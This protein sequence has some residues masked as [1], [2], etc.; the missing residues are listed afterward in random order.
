MSPEIRAAA[1]A[2]LDLALDAIEREEA[3]RQAPKVKRTRTVQAP[4]AP[5][6]SEVDP[7]MLE[8]ARRARQRAGYR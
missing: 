5:L 6:L 1:H 7:A 8:R 2:A 4:P 3:A